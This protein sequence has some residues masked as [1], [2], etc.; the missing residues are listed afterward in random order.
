MPVTAFTEPSEQA[1]LIPVDEID[2]SSSDLAQSAVEQRCHA[3]VAG[4]P[5]FE[6][7]AGAL[8]VRSRNEPTSPRL[9]GVSSD[10]KIRSERSCSTV[11]T[12]VCG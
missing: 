2:Q 11:T 12:T 6:N 10:L 4:T 5:F 8:V 3:L 7:F 9:D 1:A